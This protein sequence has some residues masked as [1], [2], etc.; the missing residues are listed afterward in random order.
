[1]LIDYYFCKVFILD[2]T[3]SSFF[4]ASVIC[5]PS[6]PTFRP[7]HIVLQEAKREVMWSEAGRRAVKFK[8]RSFMTEV[9]C[10]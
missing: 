5:V 4:Y 9:A 6:L 10:Q 1:M 8:E 3:F 2:V 7:T